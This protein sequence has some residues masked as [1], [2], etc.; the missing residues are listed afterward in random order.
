MLLA[1]AGGTGAPVGL[2]QVLA[3]QQGMEA[4]GDRLP[5]LAA[6]RF[7]EAL[8]QPDLTAEA[9][10]E[11][12]MRLAEALVRDAK[13]AEALAVLEQGDLAG[14]PECAFWKGQALAG[15]GHLEAAAALLEIAQAPGLPHAAAACFSRASVLLALERPIDALATLA[16]VTGVPNH[17]AHAEALLRQASIHFDLGNFTEARA[18][19]GQ[20]SNPPA[21]IAVEIH[22]LDARLML[23]EGH[24][25]EA[26][27]K[28][29]DLL[30]TAN[31]VNQSLRLRHS[32]AL[33]LSDAT[34]AAGDRQAAADALLV[35][36]EKNPT[37]PLLE[38][39]FER[40]AKWMP[41]SPQA[42]DPILLRVRQWAAPEALTLDPLLNQGVNDGVI[43]AFPHASEAPS[44]LAAQALFF[45]L[46]VMHD[47]P[48]AAASALRRLTLDFPNHRL[49]REALLNQ[50]G[51]MIQQ[52]R[53]AD[54]AMI[55]GALDAETTLTSAEGKVAFLAAR[56]EYLA[57][58][59]DSA[60]KLFERASASMT[61]EK[62]H[63]AA[64]DAAV[65][66]LRAGDLSALEASA[67]SEG[68]STL[69]ADIELEQALYLAINGAPEAAPRLHSF[70]SQY[71]AHK[72]IAEA[73]LALA[74][75][76]LE[77]SPADPALARSQLDHPDME[78]LAA[79]L[80][81]RSVLLRLRVEELA[82]QW[83]AIIPIA[84]QFLAQNPSAGEAPLV[85][86]KLGEALFRNKDYNAA[87]LTLQ[88]LAAAQPDSPLAEVALF[89]S[90]RAA[91]LGGTPQ[92]QEESLALYDQ[93]IARA[94]PLTEQAQV[95]KIRALIDLNRSE[96]A[97]GFARESLAK[98]PGGR[99]DLRQPIS[100]LLAEALFATGK[101]PNET[102]RYEEAL[103]I[104]TKQ[105]ATKD[106]PAALRHRLHYLRGL[107]LEQLN[108]DAEALDS[109]YQVLE[110]RELGKQ[111]SPEEWYQF[112]RAAFKGLTLLELRGRWQAAVAIA[113]KIAS[114]QG[115]RSREAAERAKK[116]RLEHMIW[117]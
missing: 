54:A 55:L 105:L 22:Y 56:A 13:P 115:P 14:V 79:P 3:Y 78:R 42:N 16:V 2:A 59:F 72:R 4:L 64:L 29:S 49:T 19:L 47:N 62:A 86:L 108:R 109:Y 67:A 44:E 83:P 106:L 96:A 39:A 98:L 15:E 93:V 41:A 10:Q 5:E 21:P 25:A 92:A 38:Q 77:S 60:A 90:A 1:V 97:V 101:G 63:T 61:A 88:A 76:A 91:S 89:H 30:E 40:L 87:R 70:L 112:E 52:G 100:I 84:Q 114:F 65:S 12:G 81:G 82:R 46:Q 48:P 20:I 18:L 110:S 23:Q 95:R 6:K 85:T 53:P 107:T 11:M 31:P 103:A 111:R 50:A 24:L 68:D 74:A 32:A 75:T 35:F 73:R 9:R 94:G 69:R 57:G 45:L 102:G 34:A 99:D 17:P 71:P 8:G 37:T 27:A 28:F 43:S 113:E 80:R 116:L 58:N 7:R 66:R 26:A 33:G 104:Y 36:I 117:E 51:W